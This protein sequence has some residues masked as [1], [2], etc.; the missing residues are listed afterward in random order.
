MNAPRVSARGANQ[1]AERIRA[2]ATEHRIPILRNVPLARSLYEV[3]I[4]REVPEDLY[5]AVAEVLHLVEQLSNRE[6]D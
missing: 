6:N 4:G 1:I 5:E 2:I 3:E